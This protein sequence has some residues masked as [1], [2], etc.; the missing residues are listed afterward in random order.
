MLV[1][2]AVPHTTSMVK[3]CRC[4]GAPFTT[5]KRAAQYCDRNECRFG[6]NKC[7]QCGSDYV[8]TKS[9]KGEFCSRECWYAWPGKRALEEKECAVCGIDF[10]PRKQEQLTCGRT[11]R[12]QYMRSN[13]RAEA[14]ATC[15]GPMPLNCDVETQHCSRSCADKDRNKRSG[16]QAPLG[17]IK[18]D[19]NNGYLLIKVG[20]GYPGGMPSSSWMPHHRYVMQQ[21]LG[22]V[23][24]THE[25]VHHKN[26]NRT[27]NRL[28][29]GHEVLGCEPTCCNLE[30]W[31][32]KTERGVA[33]DPPGVR[34][35]DYHCP[36]CRCQTHELPN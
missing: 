21:S 5:T 16:P 27:D 1:V 34:A 30:L 7:K 28:T 15:A 14:C 17:T 8:R 23:L 36:G 3:T 6:T 22:R 35:S 33:K 25:R 32:I 4:C 31:K 13:R 11:C 24:E 19:G 26:G 9:S 29:P 12:N 18:P 2:S 10:R 20:R